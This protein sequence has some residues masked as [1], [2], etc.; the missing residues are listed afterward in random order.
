M[1][2][3]KRKVAHELQSSL[4]VVNVS[5]YTD[6]IW[7]NTAW[8]IYTPIKATKDQLWNLKNIL[9]IV[10]NILEELGH[11][12]DTETTKLHKSSASSSIN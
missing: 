9:V 6:S 4:A 5:L 11:L 1:V 3:R 12:M 8:N 10:K 2:K 7:P